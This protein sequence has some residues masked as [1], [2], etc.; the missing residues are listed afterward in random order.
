MRNSVQH[1]EDTTNGV[2]TNVS[3]SDAMGP[4][5]QAIVSVL[6]TP[7]HE[8]IAAIWDELRQQF[9]I[10]ELYETPIPHI[11]YHV[12]Y[13]YEADALAQIL[14]DCAQIWAPFAITTAGLGLFTGDQPVLYIPVVRTDQLAAFR[15]DLSL[16]LQSIARKPVS[17]YQ[18]E[19]WVPHITLTLGHLEEES[20]GAI[21]AHLCRRSFRWSIP[22]NNVAVICDQCGVRGVQA[23]YTLTGER[24]A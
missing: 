19:N 14:S 21:V 15:D 17:H 18:S 10:A 13:N 24:R 22:I 2:G 16:R 23:Q 4:G 5:L 3:P 8:L 12:A 7:H 1:S 9:K 20:L 6:D 11:S